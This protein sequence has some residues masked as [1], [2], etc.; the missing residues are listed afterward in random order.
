MNLKTHS[1]S[2]KKECKVCE[3]NIKRRQQEEENSTSSSE[4]ETENEEEDEEEKGE[5]LSHCHCSLLNVTQDMVGYMNGSQPRSRYHEDLRVRREKE[6]LNNEVMDE[7]VKADKVKEA[8]DLKIEL[9]KLRRK[10][11]EAQG[12]N[13]APVPAQVY[14]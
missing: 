10:L 14:I 13:T 7:I 6:R 2:L 5:F 4:D 3:A 9:A 11:R 1:H 8:S 12:R